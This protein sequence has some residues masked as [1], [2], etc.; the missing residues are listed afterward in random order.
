MDQ[1]VQQNAAL[2]EDATDAA[3]MKEQAGSLLGLVSR[4][5][6]GGEHSAPAGK[7][8]DRAKLAPQ[9]AALG[10]PR[11]SASGNGERKEF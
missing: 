3:A 6:L 11:L 7:V 9:A 5:K 8:K 4:F 1:V 2:V 10:A